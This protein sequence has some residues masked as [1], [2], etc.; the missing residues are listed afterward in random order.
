[1]WRWW[2]HGFTP[3]FTQNPRSFFEA[4]CARLASCEAKDMQ[5]QDPLKSR[6]AVTLFDSIWSKSYFLQKIWFEICII[7]FLFTLNMFFLINDGWFWDGSLVPIFRWV[8]QN[9][10]NACSCLLEKFGLYER[11]R[12]AASFAVNPNIGFQRIPVGWI[13]LISKGRYLYR[14]LSRDMIMYT[15]TQ[16]EIWFLPLPTIN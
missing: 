4:S 9:G 2:S 14:Q 16:L 15:I 13:L 8:A 10:L 7:H 12:T 6:V 5:L 11:L 1:M 3:Y